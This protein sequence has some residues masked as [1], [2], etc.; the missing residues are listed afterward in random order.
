MVA[1]HDLLVAKQIQVQVHLNN[2]NTSKHPNK[3][4]QAESEY[5]PSVDIEGAG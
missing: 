3:D 5:R 4:N 2:G 1:T